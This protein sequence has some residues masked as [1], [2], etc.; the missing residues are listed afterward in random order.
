LDQLEIPANA[1]ARRWI[2]A[3]ISGLQRT[4]KTYGLDETYPAMEDMV[5][6]SSIAAAIERER[7]FSYVRGNPRVNGFN[8]TSLNDCW[9]TGEGFLDNFAQFKPGQLP[10]LQAGWAPLRWCLLV[11]PRTV[12]ADRP[13]RLRVSLANEDRLLAGD[14]P[15]TLQISGPGGSVWS[16]QAI[17]HFPAGRDNPFAALVFDSDVNLPADLAEGPVPP[18]V[19]TQ[20]AGKCCRWRGRL[21]RASASKSSVG[22]WSGNAAGRGAGAARVPREQRR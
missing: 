10:V 5:A 14:Y 4:W 3:A 6:D 9:G 15:T 17:A 8:L 21:Y 7:T 19:F 12:Y 20:R 2:D 18:D 16:T 13:L 1:Y 22:P 11:N